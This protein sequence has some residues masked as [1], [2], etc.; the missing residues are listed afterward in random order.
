MSDDFDIFA[1]TAL[2][3]ENEKTITLRTKV[4][5]LLMQITDIVK[6]APIADED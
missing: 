1:F 2:V 3:L 4:N 6:S 5:E